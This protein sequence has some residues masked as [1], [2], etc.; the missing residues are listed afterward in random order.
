MET[1][2]TLRMQRM[3]RGLTLDVVAEMT[4]ITASILSKT[5]RGITIL[6]PERA[7][8]LSKVYGVTVRPS[9][10]LKCS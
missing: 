6:T 4:G 2:S 7:A 3:R 9:R 5:E 1:P 8:R 10:K